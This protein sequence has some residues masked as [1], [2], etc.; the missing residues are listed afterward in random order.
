MGSGDRLQRAQGRAT[1]VPPVR[2]LLAVLAVVAVPL[3]ADARAAAATSSSQYPIQ[4]EFT[5]A[6][7]YATTNSVV[8]QNGSATYDVYYP[9]DYSKVGFLSPIIT[10][11]SG[12][13]A[14]PSMYTTLLSHLAS[15]GFTVIATTLE[16]TGSGLQID[17]A[18]HYLVQQNATAGSPF[19]GHLDIHHVA[20]VGHSQG[21]TGVVRAASAD[22]ELITAVMTFSLPSPLD[23]LSNPDCPT[24]ADC[25][26][27]PNLLKQPI[28]LLSTI[29][30]E[31]ELVDPP[32]NAQLEYTMVPGH[33]V[34][35]VILLS[36]GTFADHNS[37]QDVSAGG[38]PASE[39][40]YATAW[41]EFALR[42]N[43]R[44][45][46]A[47]MGSKAELLRNKNWAFSAEKK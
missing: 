21:A 46:Q 1:S 45:A 5:A 24:A 44:A 15:Y 2:A 27:H 39:I 8:T 14:I 23:S 9:K 16:N 31:D 18:A 4:A 34:M 29:G 19:D 12:T 10:W 11:G 25:T 43:L 40:G 28:F 6:G 37:I 33:A 22:P 26:A 20:A 42:G 7:P 35:G 41:L 32:L 38:H 36:G 47:F 13:D 3:T 30:P 17:Q